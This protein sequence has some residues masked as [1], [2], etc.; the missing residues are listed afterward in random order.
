MCTLEY[1][2]VG[3]TPQWKPAAFHS[4]TEKSVNN[5]VRRQ[6]LLSWINHMTQKT[7]QGHCRKRF[8]ISKSQG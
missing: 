1:M 2:P 3:Q 6:N 5:L 7:F 8:S 4:D